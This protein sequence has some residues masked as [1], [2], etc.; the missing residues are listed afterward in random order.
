MNKKKLL[1][2]PIS[3]VG[4]VLIAI[5]VLPAAALLRIAGALWKLLD[6]ILEHLREGGSYNENSEKIC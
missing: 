6:F 4:T 2:V 5:V 3:F 1:Y